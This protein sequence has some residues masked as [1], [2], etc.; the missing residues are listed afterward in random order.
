MIALVIVIACAAAWYILS[1]LTKPV[2]VGEPFKIGI[3][4]NLSGAYA[5]EGIRGRLVVTAL[6]EE[7]NVEGGVYLKGDD[8]YHPIE[9]IFYDGESEVARYAE[10]ASKLATEKTAHLIMFQAA[11]PPYGIP[12]VINI[13]KIG[14]VPCLPGVVVDVLVSA[15]SP[16]FL[17]GLNGAGLSTSTTQT[18]LLLLGL[19]C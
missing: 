12:A 3:I 8:A 2:E 19:L 15:A 4:T 17:E 18:L 6:A 11:P 10:L 7:I 14:G 13:E 9:L 16:F 1:Q 5:P